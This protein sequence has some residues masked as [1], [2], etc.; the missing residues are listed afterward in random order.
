MNNNDEIYTTTVFK[1][2]GLQIINVQSLPPIPQI[3]VINL[4]NIL[5]YQFCELQMQLFSKTTSNRHLHFQLL[6]LLLIIL[7]TNISQK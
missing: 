3:V 1:Q 6:L 5:T 7:S 4:Q 2:A